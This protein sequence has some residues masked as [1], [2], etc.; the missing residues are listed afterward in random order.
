MQPDQTQDRFKYESFVIKGHFPK[1]F[2]KSLGMVEHEVPLF[3]MKYEPKISQLDS[4]P[5]GQ[6][7]WEKFAMKELERL[8]EQ[9]LEE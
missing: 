3:D 1:E 7:L 9:N 2:L 5:I 8:N 6:R 4:G